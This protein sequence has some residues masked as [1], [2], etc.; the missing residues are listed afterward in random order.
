MKSTFRNRRELCRSFA[1]QSSAPTL[2]VACKQKRTWVTAFSVGA[3]F[4]NVMEES[5]ASYL[6][7]IQATIPFNEEGERLTFG[8]DS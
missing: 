1:V 3:Q 7:D 8:F 5:L 4:E 6:K 2:N